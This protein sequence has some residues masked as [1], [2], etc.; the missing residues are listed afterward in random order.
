MAKTWYP[1][2]DYTLC[3][4]CGT[5]IGKCSHG[6]YDRAKAPVPVVVHP[7][8]CVDHCHGCGNLCPSGAIVYLGEDT[9]W[10]PP[11]GAAPAREAGC[12][13]GAET[14][15][16]ETASGCA[17]GGETAAGKRVQIDY[18]Y[19]DLSRCD[20]CVETEKALRE[21]VAAISPALQLAGYAV[22]YRKTEMTT[23]EI[24]EKHRFLSSPTIRVNGR[25]IAAHVDEN[26]CGCC[27]A[28]SS[29]DV[30][31]RVFAYEGKTYEVPPK[32]MLAEGILRAALGGGT[33]DGGGPYALPEN[34]EAFYRGKAQA[35]CA[36]G[37]NCGS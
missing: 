28:I 15:C 6:V 16:E 10:T 35:A 5:C 36:C 9:G 27:S 8:G 22:N 17:C 21:V 23:R 19:L 34:L 11:H 31:C 26:R 25:D 24:A 20:R 29:G 37:G 14:A 7:E 13:C 3:A 12:C 4:E 33:A 1:V 32:Q 2:I 18:L 30:D